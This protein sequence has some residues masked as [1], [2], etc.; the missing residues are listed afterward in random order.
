M[1]S[2][3]MRKL[4]NFLSRLKGEFGYSFVEGLKGLCSGLPF[5]LD[6]LGIPNWNYTSSLL[7]EVWIGAGNELFSTFH[8]PM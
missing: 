1:S 6:Y 3:L 2:G 4:Q 5:V 8:N 7:K